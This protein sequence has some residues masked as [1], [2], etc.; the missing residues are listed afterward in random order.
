[1]VVSKGLGFLTHKTNIE[2]SQSLILYDLECIQIIEK[3][4]SV[5]PFS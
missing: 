5:V 1:M 3:T 4:Y 2:Q